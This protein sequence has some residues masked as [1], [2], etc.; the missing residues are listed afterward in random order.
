MPL[1]LRRQIRIALKFIKLDENSHLFK[2][3]MNIANTNSLRLKNSPRKSYIEKV[4]TIKEEMGLNWN[5][6]KN[7]KKRTILNFFTNKWLTNY[8]HKWFNEERQICYKDLKKVKMK[9][10]P[11]HKS[12]KINST[13]HQLRLGVLPL[14]G[15]LKPIKKAKISMCE[16]CKEEE[17]VNHLLS[18][19]KYYDEIWQKS[20]LRRKQQHVCLGQSFPNFLFL[21]PTLSKFSFMGPTRKNF[22][23]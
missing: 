21:G 1:E 15:F 14:N 2:Y 5:E 4:I 3:L 23:Q 16:K 18:Q 13:W 8:K 17:T 10:V 19:C 6:F 11:I 22:C 7:S 20:F 9:Y 12:R